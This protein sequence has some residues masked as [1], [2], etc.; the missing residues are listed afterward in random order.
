MYV[1]TAATYALMHRFCFFAEEFTHKNSG[2]DNH[3]YIKYKCEKREN[4]TEK[5]GK[6][7]APFSFTH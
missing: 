3:I 5:L 2:S 7:V 1:H 6:A 4:R